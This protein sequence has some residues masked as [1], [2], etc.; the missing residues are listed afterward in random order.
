VKAFN[1][2]FFPDEEDELPDKS[3]M[4]VILGRNEDNTIR[5]FRNIG[6]SGDIAEFIG[7]QDFVR[8]LPLWAHD[9]VSTGQAM[10][11]IAMAPVNRLFQ[12]IGPPGKTIMEIVN[13]KQYFPEVDSPRAATTGE[14]LTGTLGLAD[15]YKAFKGAV[16]KT[17]E[18]ARKRYWSS[19]LWYTADAEKTALSDAYEM[20]RRYQESKGKDIAAPET[21]SKTR[22]MRHAAQNGDKEAF[23]EARA[24]FIKDGGTLKSFKSSVQRIDPIP[25]IKDMQDYEENFL[26]PE[27][28]KKLETARA[29]AH[30]IQDQMMVWWYEQESPFARSQRRKVLNKTILMKAESEKTEPQVERRKA[31]ARREL[32]NM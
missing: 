23:L 13:Q 19:Y 21:V 28:R 29:Y 10:K 32:G 14:I 8:L 3:G 12:S 27:Q 17:G 5:Y 6:A 31:A 25:A 11:E 9:Q 20:R 24:K 7:L 1:H 30:R 26:T 18:R 22:A 2:L 4:S 16:L 15:E